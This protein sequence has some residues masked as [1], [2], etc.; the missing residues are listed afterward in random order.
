MRAEGAKVMSG[1]VLGVACIDGLG[2]CGKW[3]E[4]KEL[5]C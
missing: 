2:L 3:I 4:K 5:I 1:G